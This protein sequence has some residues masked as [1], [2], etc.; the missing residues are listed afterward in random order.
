MDYNGSAPNR[1]AR[2]LRIDIIAA[3]SVKVKK[4]RLFYREN[5][6]NA[7]SFFS[8]RKLKSAKGMCCIALS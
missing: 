4:N 2:T 1:R 6:G 5:P 7:G 3:A 8:G